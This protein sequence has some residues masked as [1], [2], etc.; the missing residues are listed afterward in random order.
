M[1]DT[2]LAP[3]GGR[4]GGARADVR[5]Q[6]HRG[7]ARP[8]LRPGAS[9]AP[10]DARGTTSSPTVVR[11][12]VLAELG[13]RARPHAAGV[14]HRRRCRPTDLPASGSGSW[15]RRSPRS[16]CRS[17]TFHRPRLA[18]VRRTRR[19]S[20]G[21]PVP[22]RDGTG[23]TCTARAAAD[24]RYVARV[25]LRP[26]RPP[27]RG[28]SGPGARG[29]ERAALGADDVRAARPPRCPTFV[30]RSDGGVRRGRVPVTAPRPGHRGVDG[31]R[32]R[33]PVATRAAP[34]ATAVIAA[35]QFA[36]DARGRR[37]R[38]AGW[39]IVYNVNDPVA[40]ATDPTVYGGRFVP[41]PPRRVGQGARKRWSGGV[42]RLR[43]PSR[44]PG[45]RA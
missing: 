41:A 33:G 24:T 19:Q 29:V 20:G 25:A 38:R 13:R 4:S 14:L 45:R 27:D 11:T 6:Q 36:Y 17:L 44:S 28:S 12:G 15:G 1:S 18:A 9:A 22:S 30:T 35:G 16:T 31:D 2:L 37:P 10:I 32:A 43:S 3:A 21:A 34:L 23:S 8:V 42:Q 5:A 26:H 7:A 40:V 39:T